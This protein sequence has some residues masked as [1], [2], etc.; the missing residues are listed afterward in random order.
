MLFEY[1]FSGSGDTETTEYNV[2]K[3]RPFVFNLLDDSRQ[4]VDT[5]VI[6]VLKTNNY[7]NASSIP[8]DDNGDIW[9]K[10]K[11][12]NGVYPTYEDYNTK[13]ISFGILNKYN[14]GGRMF[15]DTV[16]Y[17][18]KSYEDIINK[19]NEVLGKIG[20]DHMPVDTEITLDIFDIFRDN[21]LRSLL[22]G[23][24]YAN[25]NDLRDRPVADNGY[26][27]MF[28]YYSGGTVE[29]LDDYEIDVDYYTVAS[30]L[31]KNPNYY[32]EYY[33][34][35]EGSQYGPDFC[36]RLNNRIKWT[37]LD[38]LF[39]FYNCIKVL[40]MDSKLETC[41]YSDG[42]RISDV[43]DG[44]VSGTTF[45]VVSTSEKMPYDT[46]RI[47]FVGGYYINDEYGI[48]IRVS[49]EDDTSRKVTLA[50][51][52]LNKNRDVEYTYMN[53]PLYL[54]NRV[55]DK[56]VQVRVPS[57]R[58]LSSPV[59]KQ[60]KD[61]LSE[62]LN[63]K[64][65]TSIKVEYS[66]LN[67]D[68]NEDYTK[69]NPESYSVQ[70]AIAGNSDKFDSYLFGLTDPATCAL[71]QEASSDRIGASI[72]I[73]SD[74]KC[75]NFGGTWNTRSGA[76]VKLTYDIVKDFNT[77]YVLYNLTSAR[78]VD[79]YTAD[80]SSVIEWLGYHEV[81]AEF[82][83]RPDSDTDIVEDP[84]VKPKY[85]Q[86]Y[87]FT[88]VFSAYEP[89]MEDFLRY[90]PIID[91]DKENP[92][93]DIVFKYSFRLV[94]TLDDVQF[95]RKASVS[96]S[97]NDVNEMLF[98]TLKIDIP[99]ESYTV[100]NKIEE[101]QQ[102]FDKP[103]ETPLSVKYTK[104]FYNAS[105][106]VLDSDGNY[107][108]GGTYVLPLSNAPK[109]YKF[110]FRK[111]D[112]YGNLTVLDMSDGMYKLYSR[113]ANGRDIII[114]PTYSSN[115]NMALGEIEFNISIN[116]IQKLKGVPESNKFL[117]I[118]IVNQDNTISSMFDFTYE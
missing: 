40:D 47:Y 93:T 64:T 18:T 79:L 117:S 85:I 42:N 54:S 111:Y 2:G 89:L 63:V 36:D 107:N 38:E 46:I 112:T 99:V 26:P 29:Y 98:D 95:L 6:D 50:N 101:V 84:N 12:K 71:P 103:V 91:Q 62:Y 21:D 80:L 27:Y 9:Y 41:D 92:I 67:E 114:E 34:T 5:A 104:V 102:S 24:A 45:D 115:M 3:L 109:N 100:Y 55:Y 116:N 69:T 43:V 49:V 33:K 118:V 23:F 83:S 108:E 86:R 73:S 94:N 75:I 82:Y 31:Y 58:H 66:G 74:R 76:P 61:S 1:E 48:Q 56:Y 25:K 22:I 70:N 78:N 113:D 81:V 14:S 59:N 19:I 87:N 68:M 13:N 65:S 10:I 97:G 30:N 52:L 72:S 96:I 51:L 57:V 20:Y 105:N 11:P 110:R 8:H 7:I 88:E 39:A 106:I 17:T 44:Y 90:R 60:V 77:K 15:T 16:E 4:Y 28:R 53:T 32:E 35:P 37:L